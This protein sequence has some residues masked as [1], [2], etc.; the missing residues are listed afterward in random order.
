M[1]ITNTGT[2]YGWAAKAFHWMTAA[3]VIAMFA[4]A[5]YMEELPN[6]PFKIEVFNLHKSIGV[7]ILTVTV[8]RIV[9]RRI[10]P[11][12]P[13][14][15]SMRTWERLAAHSGHAV[16]YLLL[17]VM[18]VAGI[19][20][21]WFLNYPITIFGLFSLPSPVPANRDAAEIFG[22]VHGIGANVLLVT[23]ALH[24]AAALKHHFVTKDAI[25]KRMTVGTQN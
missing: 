21:S 19:L 23:F 4:I 10:S 14:P 1:A 24:V 6:T 16:L 25:L 5:W 11:P 15:D 22:A 7:T 13:L 2:D 12:P 8:L 3:A 9:W 20:H 18:P 17:V